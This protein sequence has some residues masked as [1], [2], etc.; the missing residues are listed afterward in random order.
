MK[1]IIT[2]IL[3]YGP[4]TRRLLSRHRNA[5]CSYDVKYALT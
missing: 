4:P 3:V 5:E 2:L 1:Y